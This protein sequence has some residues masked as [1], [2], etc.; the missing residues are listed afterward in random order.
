MEEENK[1]DEGVAAIPKTDASLDAPVNDGEDAGN[2]D[3]LT[4]DRPSPDVSLPPQD[5]NEGDSVD[6]GGA[7]GEE[8]G[9]EQPEDGPQCE[10]KFADALAGVCERVETIQTALAKLSGDVGTLQKAVA[11]YYTANTDSMH[12]ELEK[13]RKGLLR[14]LEQE[15]FGELIELYDT[16]DSAVVAAQKDPSQAV[17]VLEGLRDQI[18]ASLFNRGV[19]RRDAVVGEKFDPRRHHVARPD[20]PTGDKS[21]DGM[22]AA[23][24]K[25][26]FD[27]MDESFSSLRGGCMK[28]RPIWVRLYRYDESLAVPADTESQG[29]DA[30]PGEE[31]L[32]NQQ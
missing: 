15:L 26:G 30:Q 11:G 2:A 29:G 1:P 13:Y 21:L 20:V 10:S 22:V 4:E 9:N 24:A 8:A 28:L 7:S 19:E 6:A 14:K 16:A 23:S 27:D 17:S 32:E 5:A 3:V 31:F 25:A 18:D 12:R